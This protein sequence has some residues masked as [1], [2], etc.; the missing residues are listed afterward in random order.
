MS[1][2]VLP[3][4][5]PS[6]TF[7]FDFRGIDY[8]A[9]VGR[10]FDDETGQLGPIAEVFLDCAKQSSD[11]T[12]LARDAAV[13]ISL[14]LQHGCTLSTLAGAMTRDESGRAAGLAG[15]ALE[16]ALSRLTDVSRSHG[17]RGR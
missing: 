11:L 8:T 7:N 17:G 4:R 5:R 13:S 3:P 6:E 1:R 9:C 16:E 12:A 10:H 15:V 2:V 14:A